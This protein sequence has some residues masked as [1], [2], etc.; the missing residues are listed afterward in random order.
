MSE[1]EGKLNL[2]LSGTNALLFCLSGRW[3]NISLLWG[4]KQLQGQKL[5]GF[6]N[7]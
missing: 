6:P 2:A 7:S 5:L 4:P 1:E 3:Q